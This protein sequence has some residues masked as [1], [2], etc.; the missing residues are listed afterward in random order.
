MA[1]S[2][3][4]AIARRYLEL[5]NDGTP[6]FYGTDRF[7]DLFAEDVDYRLLPT[8]QRPRGF[9]VA[10]REAVRDGIKTVQRMLVHRRTH[11]HE[12]V[13]DGDRAVMRYLWEAEVGVDDHPAGPRGTTVRGEAADFITVRDGEIVRFLEYWSTLPPA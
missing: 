4:E 3:A 1:M 2:P 7:T 5:Y 12:I 13:A 8:P 6:E 11:L 10:S 9:S